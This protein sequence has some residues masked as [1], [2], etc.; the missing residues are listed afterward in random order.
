MRSLVL[1]YFLAEQLNE[2]LICCGY[3]Q[4]A[5]KMEFMNVLNYWE[6]CAVACTIL[7]HALLCV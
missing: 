1:R 3:W 7:F 6:A 4:C 2:N 5:G